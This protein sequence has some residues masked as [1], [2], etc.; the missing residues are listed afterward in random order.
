MHDAFAAA[1]ERWPGHG[2]PDN[3]R[4]WIVATARHKAIDRLRRDARFR[5]DREPPLERA[6]PEEPSDP[7][8]PEWSEAVDDRLRLIFTC[9]HPA[10]AVDARIA[11]TLR[12]L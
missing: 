2:V 3:P 5:R 1:L 9:C 10:L 6:A 12:A 4:A 7:P 11:L 8:D